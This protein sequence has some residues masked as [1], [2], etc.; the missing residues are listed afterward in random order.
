MTNVDLERGDTSV[1]LS[2][3]S[4]STVGETSGGEDENGD[5]GGTDDDSEWN[6][7]HPCFPHRNP[8]VPL[9]SPDYDAT[10][11][12]RIG[13]DYMYSGDL[14]P[15]FSYVYPE[16]LDPYIT[17]TR[18][19]EVVRTVN[20]GLFAA[21]SP[22]TTRNWVEG[23]V[24][25]LTFWLLEDI[26]NPGVKKRIREV[27]HFLED[28]NQSLQKEGTPARFVPLRRTGYLNVGYISFP[29]AFWGCLSFLYSVE[30][31]FMG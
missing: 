1:P 25:L 20:E 14:S 21:H 23:L 7:R 12:I 10:R 28:V 27:D 16:I 22:W 8:H 9:D 17:E 2:H 18:F 3:L 29:I 13:R 26:F 19:R 11:I 15:A 30:L 31:T 24:S 6:S 5:N 4:R